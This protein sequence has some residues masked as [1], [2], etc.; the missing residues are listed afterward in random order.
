MRKR[1]RNQ[2]SCARSAGCGKTRRGRAW[3]PCSAPE[4]ERSVRVSSATGCA[5]GC[6]MGCA[7]GCAMGCAAGWW[8]TG[9]EGLEQQ[10]GDALVDQ[11]DVVHVEHAAVR[12]REQ[13]RLED[14]DAGAH[15]LLHLHGPRQRD[16][17]R[18]RRPWAGVGAP[19]QP[20]YL[21]SASKRWG[22]SSRAPEGS[23]APASG[24]LERWAAASAP[25]CEQ[26]HTLS[27]LLHVDGAEEAVLHDVEGDLHEGRGDHLELE[28]AD[29][30][31]VRDHLVP[32]E[33]VELAGARLRGVV[34]GV[35]RP[36]GGGVGT[37]LW[38]GGFGLAAERRSRSPR[39]G[40][41][42]ARGAPVQV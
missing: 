37:A 9:G 34:R 39:F 40:T 41:H 21:S 30:R 11:V 13:P 7:A 6:T 12:P 36:K 33:G 15:A 17:Q 18:D 20:L 2:S 1:G 29:Q 28:V 31:V 26:G 32:Q 16:R 5:T 23:R 22:H 10:V 8:R 27:L 4:P 35:V 42:A 25:S 14:G 24:P 19:P 3:Q 38:R